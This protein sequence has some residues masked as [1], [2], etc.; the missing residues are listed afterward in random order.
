MNPI[1]P[2]AAI[3]HQLIDPFHPNGR[4]TTYAHL[5]F[6]NQHGRLAAT[7]QP[8]GGNN[9]SVGGRVLPSR[10]TQQILLIF[11]FHIRSLARNKRQIFVSA[12]NNPT[13]RPAKAPA[14]SCQSFLS[15]F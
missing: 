1:L 15:F 2:S 4:R 6:R 10:T 3:H 5:I 8:A 9:I 14:S 13:I 11:F 12:A 7:A